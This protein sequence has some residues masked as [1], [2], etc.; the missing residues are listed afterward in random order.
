MVT[1]EMVVVV[2][3]VVLLLL[4]VHGGDVNIRVCDGEDGVLSVLEV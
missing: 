3:V 2:M 1:E 4:V